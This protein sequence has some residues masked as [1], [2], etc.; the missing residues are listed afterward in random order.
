MWGSPLAVGINRGPI[1]HPPLAEELLSKEDKAHWEELLAQVG[2]PAEGQQPSRGHLLQPKGGG[3]KGKR[4]KGG[5]VQ[6]GRGD[7]HF[8]DETAASGMRQPG[9]SRSWNL[10]LG[11]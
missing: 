5:R 10:D 3:K 1:A 9:H 2:T 4:G 6:G 11:L 7:L 8:P